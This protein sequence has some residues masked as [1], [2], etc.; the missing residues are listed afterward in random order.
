MTPP[1]STLPTVEDVRAAAE[2]IR[3]IALVTPTVRCVP[4]GDA[5]G[6]DLYLKLENLQPTGAFKVRGA[7]NAIAHLGSDQRA[8]GVVAASSGNHGLA[9]AY[10]GH[11]WGV[12][13]TVVAPR[14]IPSPKAD[15][16]ET[17][18]ARL[19]RVGPAAP[20]R[21]ARAEA[22]ARDEGMTLIPSFDD[23]W[24]IAGQGTVGLEIA[25]Q[26]EPDAVLA[27][28]SGGG[29]VSG[30]AVALEAL[31]PRVRI[32]G[33]EPEG[34]AR[35]GRSVAAGSP[36]A[37]ASAQTVADGLRILSPGRLPWEIVRRRVDAFVTV[38]DQEILDA[39]R[40]LATRARIVAEPS[41]AASVAAALA[42]RGD[43]RGRV[44]AIVSG[45]NVEPA[46]LARL[47]T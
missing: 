40:L 18:G 11:R 7:A 8:R 34:A 32:I 41:G 4:L 38:S 43:L 9:V 12:P 5:A 26:I 3:E 20:E 1:E 6:L 37:L 29:L 36:V 30:V 28:V 35:F 33:V 10:V 2:L 24:V 42:R 17:Y 45:G 13:V 25:D 23:R 27:P 46:L 22:L 16:I 39:V 19:I 47:L 44:V 15:G 31:R 14:D 21:M